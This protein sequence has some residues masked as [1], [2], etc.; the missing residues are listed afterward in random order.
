L[1][2]PKKV[3]EVYCTPCT[4]RFRRFPAA[5]E[6]QSADGMT[7]DIAFMLGPQSRPASRQ[8]LLLS[9]NFITGVVG[10]KENRYGYV[11]K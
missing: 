5:E 8:Q 1:T 9:F 11:I 10:L 7:A 2:P 6:T 3:D 4:G